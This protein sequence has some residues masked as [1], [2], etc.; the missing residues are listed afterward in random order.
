MPG[1]IDTKQ[2]DK[3]FVERFTK[4]DC[5][6][7]MVEVKIP[8]GNLRTGVFVGNCKGPGVAVV[9]KGKLKNLT[10]S[11]CQDIGVVFD[12]CITTVELIGSKK[13]QCQALSTA[14][15]YVIDKCD[16]TTIFAAD[17]SMKEKV[18]IVSCMSTSTNVMTTKGDDQVENAIPDQIQSTFKTGAAPVHAV[19]IPDAE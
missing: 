6:T 15:S 3:I 2:M 4:E 10:I 11:N 17:E 8:E 14:G 7:G 9:I 16:R 18:V 12:D 1:T 13:V 5:P 19:V